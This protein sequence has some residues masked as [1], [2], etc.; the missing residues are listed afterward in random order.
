M[1]APRP[2]VVLVHGLWMTGLELAW[3]GWQLRR[4][5]Y[6]T[7]LFRYPSRRESLSANVQRLE[8]FLEA[9]GESAHLVCHS[10]GG[11]VALR[12][13]ADTPA[14]RVNR[15]VALGAPLLGSRGARILAVWPLW[16]WLFGGA[17]DHGLDGRGPDRLPPGRE[18]GVVAGTLGVGFTRLLL[19]WAM[20]SPN[21]GVVSVAET[22]LPGAAHTT[23][24]VSH[25]GMLFSRR[26]V[27]RV[28]EFLRQARFSQEATP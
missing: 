15:V 17:M 6:A 3:L 13:L 11:V 27:E 18:M 28:D 5:G 1:N 21:D 14:G 22:R 20:T 23:L 19:W 24:P 10:L 16:R 25:M 2:L 26:V 4:R 12:L 8:R 7:R 9:Q